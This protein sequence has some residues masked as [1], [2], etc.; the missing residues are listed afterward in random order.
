MPTIARL[1][2]CILTIL[3]ATT[4]YPDRALACSRIAWTAEGF[5][6]GSAAIVVGQVIATDQNMRQ[7]EVRV[8]AYA[9]PGTAPPYLLLPPTEPLQVKGYDASTGLTWV[10]TCDDRSMQFST[11]NT[12]VFFLK[13]GLPNPQLLYPNDIT[14]LLVH[15]E[16]TV[17]AHELEPGTIG[18]DDLLAMFAAASNHPVQRPVPPGAPDSQ[19]AQSAPTGTPAPAPHPWSVP[20]GLLLAGVTLGVSVAILTLR[21]RRRTIS[22]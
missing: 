19:P 15:P 10:S 22:R 17:R 4:F 5:A 21:H 13:Q 8:A 16:G 2:L 12:Y 7:A 3:L 9:G 18:V 14:A 6:R 11:G 20:A 1:I